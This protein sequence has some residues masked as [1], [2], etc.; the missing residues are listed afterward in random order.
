MPVDHDRRLLFIHIPKTG[1]TTILTLLGLW[2]KERSPELRTLFGDFGSLDLQ[3]LTLRQAEQF[4]TAA[5]FSS[6][7]RFAFVRNPWDRAVSAA[8]WR[9]RFPG[10]G[11]R[12]LRDYVDWAE[13]VNR[14]GPRQPPDCHALPQCAFLDGADGRPGVLNIG[15]FERYAEDV[16]AIL[17]RFVPIPG[18][19]PRKLPQLAREQYREYFHGD[20]ETRV[21]RLYA[22]DARRFGYRF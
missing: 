13:R 20:L 7:F 19:L 10:E 6:Y 5:E 17:G 9:T 2:K 22:E 15:R 18:P 4:L 21:G 11:V 12:D 1:G 16:A 3:H 14:I 8:L